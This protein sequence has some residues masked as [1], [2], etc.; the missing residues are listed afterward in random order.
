MVICI[1]EIRECTP[2]ISVL[3]PT[4]NEERYI[5]DCLMSLLLNDYPRTSIEILVIDGCSSD[6]TVERVKNLQL[7]FDNLRILENRKVIQAAALNIGLQVARGDI[8]LRA[9]AHALYHKEYIGNCV[10]LLLSSCASNVGGKQ[11]AHGTNSFSRAVAYSLSSFVGVGDAAKRS[12]DQSY[13]VDS[14]SFGAWWRNELIELGGFN[15]N[16]VANEDYECNYRLRLKG[17]KILYSPNIKFTY[18]PRDNIRSLAHQYYRNGF[19]R[20]KTVTTYPKSMRLR[21]AVPPILLICLLISLSILP[22]APIYGIVLPG[23]YSLVLTLATLKALVGERQAFTFY[24][25]I[26]YLTMHSSFAIGFLRGLAKWSRESY[27]T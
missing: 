21:Q 3:I 12:R 17:G 1:M 14:V 15:E 23:L 5:E 8:V 22:I 27:F 25:P 20:S 24:L 7:Q 9:D 13:L 18:F 4:L 6:S 16:W 19:W 2:F 11:I 26:V 10:Q